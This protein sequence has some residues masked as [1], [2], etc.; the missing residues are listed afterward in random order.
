MVRGALKP[1][2]ASEA[3]RMRIGGSPFMQGF[4]STVLN[5]KVA[6]FFLAALPQFV[7]TGPDAPW[8]GMLLIAIVYALGFLW[9]ALL[10]VLA[11][12]AGRKVGQS[13]AMRWFAGAM[14]VGFSGLAGRLALDRTV[15]IMASL[16]GLTM[17]IGSVKSTQTLTTAKQMVAHAKQTR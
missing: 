2:P 12:K 1:A 10:A 4:V 7:G 16:Q 6:I 5:P 13:S 15:C 14:G 8:Q 17:S 11:T 9:C 3:P